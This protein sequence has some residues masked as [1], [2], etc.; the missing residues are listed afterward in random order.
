MNTPAELEQ[1]PLSP[2]ITSSTSSSLS[3]PRTMGGKSGK[4]AHVRIAEPV[5]VVMTAS[6]AAAAAAA[7]VDSDEDTESS[8]S[9][10]GSPLPHG[11]VRKEADNGKTVWYEHAEK[12][13]VTQDKRMIKAESLKSN[14][15]S[16]KPS[17][18]ECGPCCTIS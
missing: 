12:G 10:E 3:S 1:P 18:A 6:T 9:E 7:A 5:A 13:F 16:P 8:H 14:S 11:W 2:L 4:V 15:S 17:G